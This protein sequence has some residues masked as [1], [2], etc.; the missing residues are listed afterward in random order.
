MSH[1]SQIFWSQV[2]SPFVLLFFMAAGAAGIA[3][4]RRFAPP[5]LRD[6]LLR[7]LW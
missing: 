4:V 1:A 7:R 2:L 5:R 6:F 3:L